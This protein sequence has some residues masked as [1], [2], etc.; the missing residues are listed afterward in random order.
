MPLTFERHR[1]DLVPAVEAFNRR[2][3]AAG[4]DR[5]FRL[6]NAAPAPPR[7]G[8]VTKDMFVALDGDEVRGAIMVQRQPFRVAGVR[9]EVANI[10]LPLSEGLHDKR[11]AFV[12]MWLI[13][14]VLERHPLS[15]AVG[16]GGL[17]HALPKLLHAMRWRVEPV[18]FHFKAHDVGHV[19]KELPRLR[20]SPLRRAVLDLAAATGAGWLGTRLLAL[21]SR[22]RRRAVDTLA[23]H[24]E[25]AWGAWADDVWNAAAAAASVIG[26]RDRATLEALYPSGDRHRI[27]RLEHGERTIGWAA[28]LHTRMS[29]ST[30]F[31]NLHVG[32]LLDALCEPGYEAA[33]AVAADDALRRLG[34]DIVVCNHA[35]RVWQDALRTAGCFTGPSNYLLATSP[36]LTREVEAAGGWAR[37]HVTRGDGDGRIH[38]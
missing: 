26:E 4:V 25:P 24:I 18:P 30:H 28:V 6:G 37:V 3:D 20:T 16:M 15:F 33:A 21:R 5:A 12:G 10:Q 34:V 14:S 11:Y 27:L 1:P 36:A 9:H 38:L 13:R 19:L 17:S 35:H 2:L 29:D 31:G 32:T 8:A 7:A 22:V 23:A